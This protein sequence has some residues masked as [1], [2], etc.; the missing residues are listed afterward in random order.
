MM[1]LLQKKL[2]AVQEGENGSQPQTVPAV[3]KPISTNHCVV[4]NQNAPG[5]SPRGISPRGS[6]RAIPMSETRK[7]RERKFNSSTE[8]K[9]FDK[10][11]GCLMTLHRVQFFKYLVA[12][13]ISVNV[14]TG[15]I[16]WIFSQPLNSVGNEYLNVG[17][18][19]M[20]LVCIAQQ[21]HQLYSSTTVTHVPSTPST[22]LLSSVQSS[23]PTDKLG[24][25]NAAAVSLFVSAGSMLGGHA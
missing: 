4:T 25:Q 9:N 15:L 24:I 6:P 20:F 2:A 10:V 19:C 18:A 7:D 22:S 11:P 21:A 13:Y 16:D 5:T 1:Q 14:V 23:E 8:L 3:P 17:F 12:A